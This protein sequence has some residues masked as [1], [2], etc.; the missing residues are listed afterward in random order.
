M[1]DD[2][3][4]AFVEVRTRTPSSFVGAC[5]TVDHRKQRKLAAAAQM[6]LAKH[7]QFRDHTCR[8]DVVGVN[9]SRDGDITIDWLRDAFRPGE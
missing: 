1:L 7:R 8:F 9:R 3:C 4:L 6:F 5:L 2:A